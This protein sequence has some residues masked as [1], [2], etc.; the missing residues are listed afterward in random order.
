MPKGYSS[1][2][3][4]NCPSC[5]VKPGQQHEQWCPRYLYQL[6]PY[7]ASAYDDSLFLANYM[8]TQIWYGAGHPS[9]P[10]KKEPANPADYLLEKAGIKKANPHQKEIEQLP[11]A[12]DELPF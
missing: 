12:D 3:K 8:E 2:R 4:W 11:G 6:N 5:D 7:D 10:T 1:D 9:H